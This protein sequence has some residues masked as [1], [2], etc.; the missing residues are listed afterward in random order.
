MTKNNSNGS[1][2]VIASSNLGKIKEFRQLL[3]PFPLTILGQPEKIH[4]EETGQTFADNARLKALAVAHE[5]GAWSLADDSGLSVNA[6]NGAPG[7]HSARYANSDEDRVFRLLREMKAINNRSAYFSS[8]LCIASP[9]NEILLEVEGKC[10]GLIV[11]SPR[12]VNGFGYDPIF[13]VLNTGLTFSEMETEK[14]QAL[15]HRGMAFKLL[16]PGL[17]KLLRL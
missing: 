6:L 12:G 7:V 1:V 9:N 4:V 2:L 10:E 3:S 13:E 16:L 8:A 17:K 5:T 11:K 14:K 15:S